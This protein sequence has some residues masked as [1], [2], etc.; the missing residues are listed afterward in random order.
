[1]PPRRAC[2]VCYKRKIQCLI[3]TQGDPCDWCDSQG[4]TCTF[5]RVI[6]K[7]PNKR[8]TTDVVQELSQRVETLEEA[9]QT[10][11]CTINTM[12]VGGPSSSPWSDRPFAE[13]SPSSIRFGA[14]PITLASR[15][16]ATASPS[17]FSTDVTLN[18]RLRHEKPIYR[19]SRCHTGNNWYF[20][21]IG[22]LSP[23]G[24]QWISDGAGERVFMENFD[25]FADPVGTIPHLD[26]IAF[27]ERPRPLPPREV[28]DHIVELFFD[29]KTSILFPFLESD[30]FGA[31]VDIA[32]HVDVVDLG[33]Q[34][35]IWALIALVIR[36]TD[37]QQFGLTIGP[38]DCIHEATRLL[39]INNGN[40]NLDSL[41][42]ILLLWACQKMRGQCREA[43]VT[44]TNAC[45]MVC[46][47]G[48]HF[49]LSRPAILPQHIPTY[50]EKVKLHIR[51]LFW[52][53]YCSD[54][55][56]AL[57]TDRLP[58]LTSDHC[59]LSASEELRNQTRDTNLA[60]IK[61]N[62]IRL[63]CSP[64]AFRYT[65]GE[66]LAQVR[67]LDDELEE[68]RLA[69]DPRYRPRLSIISDL[70]FS[71]PSTMSLE[72]RTYLINLQLDYLF[73]II[74]IHTLVRK[75]GDLEKNLPDDLHSVVHSSADLSIEAS[76]S[77][78]R[79]LDTVVDFW[80]E[81]S[82]WIVSHYAPMAAMP[83][84]MNILIHPLGHSADN[85]LRILSSISN[86]TRK[87]PAERLPME[88]IEHIQEISE[89]VMELV[90]LSH[91]AAWKVKRGE[92]EHD[93]DIIHT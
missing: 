47:L 26:P 58:L 25:I 88:E 31:T 29:S 46:D 34:A 71:L 51:R 54:K 81:D 24:R 69:V 1:M 38:R 87:V 66:L 93:L 14:S 53:C 67:Q 89:F 44:F 6:H 4:L 82:L 91:S 80:K 23:R 56:I 27:A 77:I 19:L 92:R 90:R 41:Q 10:A 28:C 61:E 48:G 39:T 78:F 8:T 17:D 7:D 5:D 35:C 36:T 52:T 13:P 85:D 22:I 70:S 50:K 60:K 33:A 15:Q 2:D 59:D 9:L 16:P 76:R 57:R 37:P 43:S 42:A 32:Y 11:L 68:W 40:T 20:K 63:L 3:K 79:I 64:R 74:N 30:I 84:F 72:N 73:T 65:E 83:L 45:R 86:I 21:G 18:Q 55:D 75:C 12:P 49:P 62:A